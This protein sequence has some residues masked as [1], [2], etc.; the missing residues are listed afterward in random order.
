MIPR[1]DIKLNELCYVTNWSELLILWSNNV[2]IFEILRVPRGN[3]IENK[4][5]IKT[6]AIS[7]TLDMS[8]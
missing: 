2:N 6:G 7:G 3:G 1:S 5:N 8:M 4:I